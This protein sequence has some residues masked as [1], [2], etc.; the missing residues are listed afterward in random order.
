MTVNPIDVGDWIHLGGYPGGWAK[1][2]GLVDKVI[3]WDTVEPAHTFYLVSIPE[4]SLVCTLLA[5]GL[6][7]LRRK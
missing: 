1:Y 6:F 4:P 3:I 2:E 5:A 7:L